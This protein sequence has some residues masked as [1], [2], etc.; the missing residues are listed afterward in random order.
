MAHS[1]DRNT[2]PFRYE[3]ED[4]T[5]IETFIPCRYEVCDRC[6]G[7]G[8]IVNPAI[9]GHGISQEE[10]DED[11]DFEEG[12]FSGRYDIVCPDCQ[13][14]RVVSVPDESRADPAVLKAYHDDKRAEADY[15][16]ECEAERRFCGGY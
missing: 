16:R 7:S 8:T 13:G 15:E 10:F 3:T 5:E 14:K 1:H 9:D 4:G 11:P 12:Y 2:I 6:R